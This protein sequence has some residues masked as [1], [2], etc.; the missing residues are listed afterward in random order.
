[1]ILLRTAYVG[2][3]I[4]LAKNAELQPNEKS[5][6]KISVTLFLAKP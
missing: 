2:R 5:N 4:S 1:M 3:A 6:T